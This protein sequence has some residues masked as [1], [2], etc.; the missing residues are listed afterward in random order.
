MIWSICPITT[1]NTVLVYF[2]K[3]NEKNICNYFYFCDT[4]SWTGD[5]Q[6]VGSISLVWQTVYNE[7]DI[8]TAVEKTVSSEKNKTKQNKKRYDLAN[9]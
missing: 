3:P 1:I 6:Y 4:F 2:K 9:C 7:T 5:H 8:K